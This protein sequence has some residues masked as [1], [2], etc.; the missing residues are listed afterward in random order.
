[1]SGSDI[2]LILMSYI[3][4]VRIFYLNRERGHAPAL[5]LLVIILILEHV[6]FAVIRWQVLLLYVFPLYILIYYALRQIDSK[7]FN[8]RLKKY[9]PV[10]VLFLI[11]MSTAAMII[12]PI[13]SLEAPNGNYIVGTKTFNISDKERIEIY[14]E[15]AGKSRDLR[16]QVWYPADTDNNQKPVKWMI[17]GLEVTKEYAKKFH[18]LSFMLDHTDLVLSHS[19]KD[20][21]VSNKELN[22]PVVILSHG[23]TSSRNFHL[24]IAEHLASNGFIVIGIDHTYSAAAT[25]LKD[26]T[27]APIDYSAL[28]VKDV[29]NLLE[30]GKVLIN[31]YS[32]DIKFLLDYLQVMNSDDNI[33]KG[34]LNQKKIG[35]FGH[36]TGAGAGV[37]AAIEDKRIIAVMGMD[38]W[39]EPVSLETLQK[40]L[41]VNAHF[42][43]SEEWADKSNNEYLKILINNSDKIEGVL[44]IDG[45][46]HLDF[47]M[48]YAYS[49][50]VKYLGLS[51]KYGGYEDS[52][53]QQEFVLNFFNRY[54][55]DIPYDIKKIVSKYEYIKIIEM[56]DAQ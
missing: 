25:R 22:Y 51:G 8:R 7:K 53:I 29:E 19:Y 21:P 47:T 20:V 11:T 1:M 45:S 3:A 15:T 28:D 17:D 38:P 33:L 34:K 30:R 55:K 56:K 24:N 41:D 4:T 46:K 18:L 32:E 23:W 39:L 31:V 16:I 40:G 2:L 54:L 27:V 9:Y 13:K 12:L 42:F 26:G 35:T 49:D 44:Q 5:T 50:I 48:L 43:R 10:G 36:S 52:L 37:K 6:I 14:G